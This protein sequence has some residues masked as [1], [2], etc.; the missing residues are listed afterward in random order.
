MGRG[1]ICTHG[2]FEGLYFLDR[3]FIDTYHKVKRCACGCESGRIVGVDD[4]HETQTAQELDAVGIEYSFMDPNTDWAFDEYGTHLAWSDMVEFFIEEF[5]EK[6]PSFDRVSCWRGNDRRVVLR[7]HLFEIA[8][9][10]NEWS[11]AWMLLERED[12]GD[13][14]EERAEMEQLYQ[15]YLTAIRDILIEGWGEAVGYKGAW[16]SGPIYT[17]SSVAV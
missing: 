16:T 11:A 2:E 14:P 12:S 9:A 8:V 17:K 5:K 3:K 1:N 6:F 13:E 4:D 7:D 15:T 10:D